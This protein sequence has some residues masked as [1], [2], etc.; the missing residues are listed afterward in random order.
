MFYGVV[1]YLFCLTLESYIF[2]K[3]YETFPWFKKLVVT[4]LF[5][6]GK[7]FAGQ[8]FSYF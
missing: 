2:A 6:G 5:A 7:D 1:S 3:V 8:Y 4:Y